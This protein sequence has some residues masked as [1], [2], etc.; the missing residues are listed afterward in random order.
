VLNRKHGDGQPEGIVGSR[1]ETLPSV[2]AEE[3][4]RESTYR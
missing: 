3:E 1:R 4:Q 2:V